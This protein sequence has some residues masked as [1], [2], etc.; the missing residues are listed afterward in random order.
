M[1]ALNYK[2]AIVTGASSG[3]GAA[4]AIELCNHGVLVLA[5]ARRRSNLM[6]VKSSIAKDRQKFFKPIVADIAKPNDT[7][8][9]ID[10]AKKEGGTDLLI[11][12][13]GVGISKS[14]EKHSLTNAEDIISTNLLGTIMLTH[15]SLLN[16]RAKKSLHIVFVSSLAGKI[17]FPNLS[18]YSA[19]KFAIEGLAESL[20]HEYA[21]SLVRITVLRPGVTDT[22]FFNVA[23]M[24]EYY[25]SVKKSKKIHT[26]GSV[27]NELLTNLD[28]NNG[29][30]MVGGDRLFLR[31]LPFVPFTKRF[32]ILNFTNTFQ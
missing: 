29:I 25:N 5:V 16:R 8:R 22:N 13:A 9:I 30:I 11:N 15:N 27:A 7:K 19:T 32:K 28:D 26:A 14:F 31:I 2:C 23:G 18:V 3:I 12:N 24:K 6:S 17:G 10:A 21:N 4:I 1:K 20:R